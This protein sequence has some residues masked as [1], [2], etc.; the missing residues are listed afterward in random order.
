MRPL[1]LLLLVLSLGGA[2]PLPAQAQPPCAATAPDL[3]G[4]F[5][6]PNAPMRESTGRGLTVSGAVKSA[7]SCAP[8]PGAR[9]EWWQA[10][11]K[12]SYDDDHRATLVATA[13]GRYRLQTDFPPPYSGRPAHIHFRVTAPGHRTLITQLYPRP[14]QTQ[15]TFNLVLEKE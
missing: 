13:D 6:K 4:P 1:S 14:G 8:I 3:E 2:A 7:G 5:Y 15:M 11:P 12:G 9:V 10:N